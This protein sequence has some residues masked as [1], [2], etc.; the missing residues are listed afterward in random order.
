MSLSTPC[1]RSEWI[2]VVPGMYV[3]F[4]CLFINK[5]DLINSSLAMSLA[6]RLI[7]RVHDLFR[8][9]DPKTGS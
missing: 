1:L 5:D 7:Y 2:S 4:F 9:C 6:D 3:F 8:T